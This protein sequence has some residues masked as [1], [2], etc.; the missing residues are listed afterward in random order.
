[1][2]DL[3]ADLRC[4]LPIQVLGMDLKRSPIPVREMKPSPIVE[5]PRRTAQPH[6]VLWVRGSTLRLSHSFFN[7]PKNDSA[8][9]LSQ[10]TPVLPTER[11]ILYL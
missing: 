1:M 11:R 3:R 10:H 6:G 2:G 5:A 7:A 8:I 9:A 4:L